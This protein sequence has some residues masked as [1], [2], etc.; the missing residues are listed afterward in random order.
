ML[1]VMSSSGLLHDSLMELNLIFHM[2]YIV[3]LLSILIYY[4]FGLVYTVG[5]LFSN[6]MNYEQGNT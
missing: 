5:D 4:Y 3:V 6:A 1:A 2:H